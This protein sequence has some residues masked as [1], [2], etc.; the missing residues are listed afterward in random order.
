MPEYDSILT[1]EYVKALELL[2]NGQREILVVQYQC[3]RHEVSSG[4][5]SRLIG[6]R[7]LANIPYGKLAHL[8]CDT[9][10][11]TKPPGIYW[12]EALSDAYHI[13]KT[14]IWIMRPNLV[15]A[16]KQLGWAREESKIIYVSPEEL[17]ATE[18][19][20]EGN[21][22][23]V[24]VNIFERNQAART[25]CLRHLGFACVVCGFDFEKFYGELGREFIHVHH[26]KPLSE[27]GKEYKVDPINDLCPVCPN[28]HAMLHKRTPTSTVSELRK[29]IKNLCVSASLR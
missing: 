29:L 7:G 14:W 12:F 1:E 2:Q 27:I 5:L 11:V 17:P 28:C 15:A 8:I 20:L 22:Q 23:L 16:I 25:A 9:L 18:E 4:Q 24:A 10:N 6:S 21:A 13:H 19:F 3:P 26:I